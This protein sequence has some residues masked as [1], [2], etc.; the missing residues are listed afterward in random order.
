ML[1]AELER[2]TMSICFAREPLLHKF[3]ILPYTLLVIVPEFMAQTLPLSEGAIPSLC[4]RIKIL[5]EGH[6][7]INRVK[8]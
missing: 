5:S 2:D 1:N 3:S 7:Y 8:S 4:W 6:S